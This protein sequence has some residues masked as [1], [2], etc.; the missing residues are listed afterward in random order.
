MKN[1][2]LYISV[3]IVSLLAAFSLIAW[4]YKDSISK[5]L[6]SNTYKNQDKLIRSYAPTFGPQDAKVTIVEFLDPECESCRAFYPFVKNIINENKN[7]IRLVVRYAP[8]HHN[9]LFAAS[10]LE[11]IRLQGKYWEALELFLELQPEWGSHHNPK[12]ELLWTYLPLLK[13]DVEKVKMDMESS[14]IKKNIEQDISDVKDLVIT[15]TPT[16]YVNGELLTQFGYNELRNLVKSK[17][18]N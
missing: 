1:D 8:F 3:T 4:M 7:D 9:S 16:F 2:K 13:I 5:E 12:P 6:L 18:G 15:K 17:L 14:T 10:M 11:A